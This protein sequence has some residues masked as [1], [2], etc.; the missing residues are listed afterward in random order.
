MNTNEIIGHNIKE[1][2]KSFGYKQD[3][4]AN[5]LSITREQISN[6]ELGKRDVPYENIERLCQL[7]GIGLEAL[8]EENEE[9]KKANL[10]FAF[11]NTGIDKDTEA[12]ANF[13]KIVLNYINIDTLINAV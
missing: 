3:H 6:Y 2:R 9:I 12:I 4:L 8:L 1:Y 7:F 5:Y 11:R 13:K 10:S